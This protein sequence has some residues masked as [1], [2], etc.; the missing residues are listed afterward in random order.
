[1]IYFGKCGMPA[2]GLGTWLLSGN[3]CVETVKTA[4]SLGYRHLDTAQIYGNEKDVGRA[5][6]NS[7][8]KRSDIFLVTKI[9]TS[10]FLYD[11][12]VESTYKSLEE[13]GSEYIDLIL[14]HW[15]DSSVPV[16]ET[17]SAMNE[18]SEKGFVKYI[19]L[20]NFPPSKVEEALLFGDIS[21]NQVEYHPYLSQDSLISHSRSNNYVLTAYCP[22][23]KGRVTGDKT[24][25]EIGERYSRTASQ[26]TLRWIIQQG[27]CA[28]PK[29]SGADHL[30]ENIDIFDFELEDKEMEAIGSLAKGLHLDP[31]SHMSFE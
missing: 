6:R 25:R 27:I 26:V 15:P 17:V 14:M 10:N 23:A 21:C 8:I 31:V 20:S 11:D 28:I 16:G 9:S 1:M 2:L 30:R 24:L 5:V 4:L 29:S 3:K 7:G 12:A 18:L 19:G 13:L 22:I